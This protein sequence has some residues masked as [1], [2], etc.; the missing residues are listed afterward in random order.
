M[1]VFSQG[2]RGKPGPVGSP[3]E[4]GEK[5]R[6]DCG[7]SCLCR[8]VSLYVQDVFMFVFHRALRGHTGQED[9][10]VML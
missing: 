1:C 8:F 4:P 7:H 9:N 6:G 2:D 3:G 5:V 10:Q